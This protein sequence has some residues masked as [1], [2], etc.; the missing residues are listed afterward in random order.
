MND[1]FD[2]V[3]IGGGPVGSALA[4]SLA[5]SNLRVA[6]LEARKPAPSSGDGRTLALSYGSRLI[7]ERIG[8]WSEA[9]QPTPIETVH[10]SQRGGFGRTLLRA[11]DA[12]VPALGYTLSYNALSNTLSDRLVNTGVEYIWDATVTR[13]GNAGDNA[14][15]EARIAGAPNALQARLAVLADGGR[16]LMAQQDGGTSREHDRATKNE[17]Y[18]KDYAQCALTALVKTE[19]A[20]NACAYERF[21]LDGPTALLPV[22]D[23]YALVWIARQARS[24]QLLALSDAE[25][26]AQLQQHFGDRQGRFLEVGARAAF[27]LSL[28]YA[29]EVAL[30]GIVRVGNAAQALHPVAGQ[31]F[32]LGLRDVWSLSRLILAADTR[33]LNGTA[34]AR[35]YART[36]RIDRAVGI[37]LTDFL[38]NIFAIDRPLPR[39]ARAAGLLLLEA[40]GPLRR[41]FTRA[42]LFG[43]ASR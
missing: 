26:L 31:G 38:V 2:I 12:G 39:A 5:R 20:H 8:A 15:I 27:P 3:I 7:L 37:G 30:P 24:E 16:G 10:V 22:R 13:L 42:M 17:M 23:R 35:A 1:A 34:L 41:A 25:F 40:G 29:R 6:V 14:L 18:V 33:A 43:S 4:L 19:L 28:R 36:R 32:N 9:L 21:T 11:N